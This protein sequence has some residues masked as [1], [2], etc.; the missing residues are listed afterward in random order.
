MKGLIAA[1]QCGE[2]SF[3][4]SHLKKDMEGARP[5]GARQAASTQKDRRGFARRGAKTALLFRFLRSRLTLAHPALGEAKV[6]SARCNQKPKKGDHVMTTHTF[7]NAVEKLLPHAEAE[8]E[9]LRQMAKQ[10]PDEYQDG[11]EDCRHAVSYAHEALQQQ[12][13]PVKRARKGKRLPPDPEGMNDDR[14]EWAAAALRHFQCTTGTDY[15]D[16][17]TDLLI[18]SVK[19]V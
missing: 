18:A 3:A 16:A 13:T 2:W 1:P 9:N 12:A 19:V 4:P 5:L 10:N 6:A 17:L 8:Q 7:L 11:Y 14:A 15:D